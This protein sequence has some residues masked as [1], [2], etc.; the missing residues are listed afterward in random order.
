MMATVPN[1]RRRATLIV[2]ALLV[3]VSAAALAQRGQFFDDE[4]KFEPEI[5]NVPYDGRFTFVRLKYDTAPGGCWLRGLPAWA[6]GYPQSEW[7]LM[8]IISELTNLGG[9]VEESNVL[10]LGDP[11]LFK[12][13]VA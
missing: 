9:R 2:A 11:Q 6:H 13:P 8:Q 12:Y 10:A 3:L 4:L 1:V 7:N 5:R